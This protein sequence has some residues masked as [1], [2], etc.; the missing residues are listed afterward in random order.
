[1]KRR[2]L[3]RTMSDSARAQIG[4]SVRAQRASDTRF[5][6]DATAIAVLRREYCAG[7]YDGARAAFP[8]LRRSQVGAAVRRYCLVV[9]TT[10]SAPRARSVWESPDFN[11]RFQEAL[12]GFTWR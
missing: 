3:R 4:A 2:V 5:H 6:W 8:Q 7:G 10:T 11:R 1:M 12:A 9:A